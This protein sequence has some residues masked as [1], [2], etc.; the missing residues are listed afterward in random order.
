M[1]KTFTENITV[2]KPRRTNSLTDLTSNKSALFESTI[3]SLPNSS[4][5]ESHDTRELQDRIKQLQNEL[6]SANQEIDNLNIENRGLKQ[7][8]EKKDKVIQTYKKVGFHG[9]NCSTPQSG[10]KRKMKKQ[11]I[12]TENDVVS[13]PTTSQTTQGFNKSQGG[14]MFT[15]SLDDKNRVKKIESIVNINEKGSSEQH[16]HGRPDNLKQV[17]KKILILADQQ[18]HGLRSTLQKLTGEDFEVSSYW[19]SGAS[20]RDII[21]SPGFDLSK[22]TK[23]DYILVIGGLNNA[24]PFELLLNLNIW[25]TRTTHTNVIISE[26]PFSK[27]LREQKLNYELRFLCNKHNHVTYLDMNYSRQIPQ[28]IVFKLNLCR[29]LLREILHLDYKKRISD[30]RL[31]L[32]S[33]AL[34]KYID[35]STQTDVIDLCAINTIH[36]KSDIE[37]VIVQSDNDNDNLNLFRV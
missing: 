3:L 21:F 2:R 34:K 9:S 18:G 1:D 11:S 8:L 27:Y 10:R 33:I 37:D 5:D 30:F 4:M 28:N 19:K 23:N 15:E 35:N 36:S 7:E 22:F 25:L 29:S 32:A 24:N 6:L 17:K 26:I 31:H 13:L 14:H 12:V 16:N 20:L